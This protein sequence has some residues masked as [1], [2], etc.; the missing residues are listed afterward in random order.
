MCNTFNDPRAMDDIRGVVQGFISR[1]ETFT[2]AHVTQSCRAQGLWAG[3]LSGS[4][5]VSPV[6]RSLF[7]DGSMGNYEQR[8][9][10]G[11]F[12]YAPPG[13]DVSTLN[14]RIGGSQWLPRVDRSTFDTSD[15]GTDAPRPQAATNQSRTSGTRADIPL[16]KDALRGLAQVPDGLSVRVEYNSEGYAQLP[17]AMV[18]QAG[19][20]PG[21]GVS[22]EGAQISGSCTLR[23]ARDGEDPAARCQTANGA[24]RIRD[25]ALMPYGVG[26]NDDVVVTLLNGVIS[27]T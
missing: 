21:D 8:D 9:V 13:T 24:L 15:D 5:G 7:R 20:E 2:A 1:G 3:T 26:L 23:K 4:K 22:I 17:A 6:V 18:K 12:A 16:A 11:F 25:R 10:G 19:F 14:L 27:L